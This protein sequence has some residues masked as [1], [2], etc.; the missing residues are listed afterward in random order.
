FSDWGLAF[1]H[2]EAGQ[3]DTVEG[4]LSLFSNVNKDAT[5][6]AVNAAV[7]EVWY[8]HYFFDKQLAITAG[9]IDAT[10][11]LD[12]NEYA[13][14]ETTQFLGRIFKNSPAIEW[15]ADNNLGIHA[16]ICVEP[17]SFLEFDLGYFEGD[18]DWDDIFDHNVYTAQVNLK[19]AELF[20]NI[21]P[22]QWSGNYRFYSWIND[23]DHTKL[24]DEG[25]PATDDY[26][27]MNYGFGI[28]CD[29]M[30]TDVFGIF[31]RFGWQRP[32]IILV[33]DS[34]TLE[35]AWSAGAQM[36][37]YYWNREDDVLAFAIGQAF[38]SEEWDDASSTNYAA[39]EG[40][41]EAYYK[42]QI[43]EC[44]AISPDIQLIWHPNGVRKSSEGDD[45]TIFVYGIRGQIDF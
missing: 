32:N 19:P 21:D 27:E 23:R 17:I 7:V 40:H 13:N 36:S 10:C 38:P 45:D 26:K 16:N 1:L 14:D 31:G 15:P 6:D 9:K 39:G 2:L 24:V 28:S 30:M 42:C 34:A 8:E 25:D 3:G 11:Y 33:D 18:G 5:G 44:L 35:C 4:E 37:G 43:N 22:D 20:D 12:Q 41:I 29:Q